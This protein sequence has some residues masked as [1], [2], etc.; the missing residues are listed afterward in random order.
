MW[1]YNGR[2]PVYLCDGVGV[3][4]RLVCEPI[5]LQLM[6]AHGGPGVAPGGRRVQ[7]PVTRHNVVP[8]TLTTRL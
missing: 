7:A 5:L 1:F 4:F 3:E 2:N 8:V 6:L